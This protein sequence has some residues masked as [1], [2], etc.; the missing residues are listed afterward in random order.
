MSKIKRLTLFKLTNYARKKF[1]FNDVLGI[2]YQIKSKLS[3]RL[4][5]TINSENLYAFP[6]ME[7][8]TGSLLNKRSEEESQLIYEHETLKSF[9]YYEKNKLERNESFRWNAFY[10]LYHLY[11]SKYE[12]KYREIIVNYIFGWCVEFVVKKHRNQF[13][14]YDMADSFRLMLISDVLSNE[15]YKNHINENC[16]KIL[17]YSAKLHFEVLTNSGNVSKGNHRI[18]QLISVFKYSKFIGNLDISEECE[19][20]LYLFYYKQFDE[21]GIHLEHSPEYHIWATILYKNISI[22][23]QNSER[24][25]SLLSKSFEFSKYLF[26][27]NYE[28]SLIGD[29]GHDKNREYREIIKPETRPKC[30]T[31]KINKHYIVDLHDEKGFYFISM[32]TSN[33]LVHKHDDSSTFE[34]TLAGNKLVTDSGKYSYTRDEISKTIREKDAHNVAYKVHQSS[35]NS[36]SYKLIHFSN[37]NSTRI[38]CIKGDGDYSDHKRFFIL[39]DSTGIIVI[40]MFIEDGDIKSV[41]NFDAASEWMEFYQPILGIKSISKEK[42]IHSKFYGKVEESIRVCQNVESISCYAISSHRINRFIIAN[43]EI[44]FSYRNKEFKFDLKGILD[45]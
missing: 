26:C 38:Y 4:I 37:E 40:D 36:V 3:K 2:H 34:F 31:S 22:S 17:E 14:W 16:R 9:R 41:L 30:Q 29:S 44:C 39:L 15:N 27:S 42:A 5:Y 24:Y 28:L 8:I 7:I 6:P 1:G 23:L 33:S 10:P 20:D 19:K 43:N 13:C 32:L 21:S 18:F 25:A 11:F 35:I 45:V 12:S